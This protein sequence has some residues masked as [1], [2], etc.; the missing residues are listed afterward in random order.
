MNHARGRLL[1]V[2]VVFTIAGCS[3][4]PT[5]EPAPRR[6][7]G[8]IAQALCEPCGFDCDCAR[9]G[10]EGGLP[11]LSGLPLVDDFQMLVLDYERRA[12]VAADAIDITLADIRRDFGFGETP[13][14]LLELEQFTRTHLIGGLQTD[15][16][17]PDCRPA[18]E[19]IVTGASRCDPELDPAAA[20]VGDDELVPEATP[21]CALLARAQARLATTCVPAPVHATYEL[22]DTGD[23]GEQ[24]R[25]ET[26]FARLSLRVA[27]MRAAIAR[28]DELLQIAD[29]LAGPARAALRTEI[30]AALG[31]DPTSFELAGLTCTLTSLDDI[32]ALLDAPRGRLDATRQKV[33]RVL[34]L[35]L[36]P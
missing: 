19:A 27:T 13:D 29:D 20:T 15:D 23:P 35:G 1:S 9:P 25:A 4:A 34:Y 8:D 3:D 10:L 36:A 6:D 22:A 17:E 11:R 21:A 28:A 18:P 12:D 7:A 26:G 5:S 24:A 14:V 31:D 16:A 2:I 32:D 33:I 30:E